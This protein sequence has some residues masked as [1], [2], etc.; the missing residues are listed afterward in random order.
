[1]KIQDILNES[2]GQNVAFNDLEP[3]HIFVLKKMY[4]NQLN[5]NKVSDKTL[6]AVDDLMTF[7]LVDDNETV[8]KRGA[9]FV[10]YAIEHGGSLQQRTAASRNARGSVNRGEKGPRARQG[11]L[12]RNDAERGFEG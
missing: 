7:G 12:R 10:K 8:T 9:Q 6:T 3:L 1:M 4:K 2:F 5:L 11:E